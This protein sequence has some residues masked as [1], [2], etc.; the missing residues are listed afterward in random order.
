[1]WEESK[2]KLFSFFHR[3]TR[4][5]YEIMGEN[6]VEPDRPEVTGNMR[7]AYRITKS[8]IQTHTQNM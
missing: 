5:F 6:M 1:M 8:R 2:H 4:A 3:A 7:F